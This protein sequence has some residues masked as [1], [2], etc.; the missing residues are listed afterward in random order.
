MKYAKNFTTVNEPDDGCENGAG[1]KV[2]PVGHQEDSTGHQNGVGHDHE[3][4]GYANGSGHQKF[5]GDDDC[6]KDEA[7]LKHAIFE[8]PEDDW[9]DDSCESGAGAKATPVGHQEDSTGHQ[10]GVGHDHESIG[11]ANGL[12]HQKFHANDDCEK[13]EVAEIFDALF[14]LPPLP[15]NDASAELQDDDDWEVVIFA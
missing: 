12:G 4:T 13:D 8:D 11:Y 14:S 2:T 10:N 5:H 1:S 9:P 15:E 6:E 3:S 7:D